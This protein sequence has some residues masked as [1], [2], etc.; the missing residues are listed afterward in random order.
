ME[1]RKLV[2]S[3]VDEHRATGGVVI[4]A[5]HGEGFTGARSLDLTRLARAI[6]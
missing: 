2:G 1:G 5:I 4:A 6:A 3:L